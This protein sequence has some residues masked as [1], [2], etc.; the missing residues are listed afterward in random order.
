MSA[1]QDAVSRWAPQ[2]SPGGAGHQSVGLNPH[3]PACDAGGLGE[4]EGEEASAIVGAGAGEGEG[5]AAQDDAGE[6]ATPV[7]TGAGT[8][9]PLGV[10]AQ[11]SATS[12]AS[13]AERG[14]AI[15]GQILLARPPR[16]HGP[17]G[18]CARRMR[19]RHDPD[20]LCGAA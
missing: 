6:G 10:Q 19:P 7:S 13:R 15:M 1:L 12:A 11:G 18:L 5:A 8:A 4:G 3:G 17:A 2:G 9:P 20:V 14:L 16:H